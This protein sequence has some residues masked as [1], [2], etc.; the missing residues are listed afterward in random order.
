M[1]PNLMQFLSDAEGIASDTAYVVT[2]SS[3]SRVSVSDLGGTDSLTFTDALPTLAKQTP[4]IM[5]FDRISTDLTIDLNRDG[6]SVWTE[7][8]LIRNF[9]ADPSSN[10]PGQ[11]FIETIGGISGTDILAANFSVWPPLP[12]SRFRD[13]DAGDTT[14]VID[15]AGGISYIEDK[16]GTDTITFTGGA[17][18]LGCLLQV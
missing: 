13:G 2:A 11:G 17:P 18:T 1:F 4:G 8:L 3:G 5:G 15:V 16:G 7:D 6:T 12:F 10:L 9:F 14:F